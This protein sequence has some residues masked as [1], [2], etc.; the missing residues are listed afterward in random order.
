MYPR[1]KANGTLSVMMFLAGF[2]VFSLGNSIDIRRDLHPHRTIRHAGN[3]HFF[4]VAGLEIFIA[5]SASWT[6]LDTD[7]ALAASCVIVRGTICTDDDFLVNNNIAKSLRSQYISTS[8]YAAEAPYAEV[9]IPYEK[10]LVFFAV[11]VLG[12]VASDIFL[13]SDIL[14]HLAKLTHI[15]QRTTALILWHI[16]RTLCQ[17]AAFLLSTGQAGVRMLRKK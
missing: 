7:A 3:Q 12:H 4:F 13:D 14:S 16:G 6:H 10:W 2:V 17:A 1:L 9:V 15:K 11:Q 8:P 5:K